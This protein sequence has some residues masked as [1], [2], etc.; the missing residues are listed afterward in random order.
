M[1]STFFSPSYSVKKVSIK[2]ETAETIA[3]YN[4]GIF[5]TAFGN[6]DEYPSDDFKSEIYAKTDFF[7]LRKEDGKFFIVGENEI[8]GFCYDE[9][10][11][12]KSD[13]LS[14][15]EKVFDANSLGGVRISQNVEG[16]V[17][18]FG[19][20]F[21]K[22]EIEAFNGLSLEIFGFELH[23]QVENSEDIAIAKGLDD[24]GGLDGLIE[25]LVSNFPTTPK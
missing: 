25:I 3:S 1:L 8:N 21:D 7:L 10:I 22:E 17:T 16:L 14:A 2:K 23:G 5:E 9:E 18:D 4:F 6:M 15:I 24:F 13:F 12:E 20:Y 11:L 19:W